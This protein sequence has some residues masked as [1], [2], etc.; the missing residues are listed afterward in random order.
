MKSV[1]CDKCGEHVTERMAPCTTCSLAGEL[2]DLQCAIC[3]EL[4]VKVTVYTCNL[5]SILYHHCIIVP[6]ISTTLSSCY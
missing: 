2:E 3:N 4:F 1:K 5:S 6:P